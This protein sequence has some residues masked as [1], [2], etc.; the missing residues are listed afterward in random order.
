MLSDLFSREVDLLEGRVVF[1]RE[2]FSA[3]SPDF[4]PR[5]RLS[6]EL[7]VSINGT[8]LQ[9]PSDAGSITC[10]KRAQSV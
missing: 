1:V 6:R 7:W 3:S 9:R 10:H 5:R 8:R 4:V 2:S